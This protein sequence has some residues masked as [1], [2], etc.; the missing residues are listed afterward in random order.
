MTQT[1]T[2]R[3]EKKFKLGIVLEYYP[4]CKTTYARAK[5]ALMS[6]KID[7]L[8]VGNLELLRKA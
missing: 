7:T 6:G 4:A 5:V 1:D 8:Y 2:E 3:E